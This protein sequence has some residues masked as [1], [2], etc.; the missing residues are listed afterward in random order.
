MNKSA[1][2]TLLIVLKVFAFHLVDS[3]YNCNNICKV[4]SFLKGGM[5]VRSR[6]KLQGFV[7]LF[8]YQGH[9]RV[10]TPKNDIL[11]QNKEDIYIKKFT[12]KIFDP[13]VILAIKL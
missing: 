8:H 7:L 12:A 11:T 13:K 2:N 5:I 10:G 9:P 1:D 6:E 3:V 4:K